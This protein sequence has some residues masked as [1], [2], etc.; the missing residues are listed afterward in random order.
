M[1]GDILEN[2]KVFLVLPIVFLIKS[3]YA[4][5]NDM[6]FTGSDKVFAINCDDVVSPI[7]KI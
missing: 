5:A 3:E 1:E 4:F 6:E 2:K 7:K